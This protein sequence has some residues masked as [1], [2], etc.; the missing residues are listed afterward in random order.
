MIFV[1]TVEPLEETCLI[2][3]SGELDRSTADRL[4]SALDAARA[5]GV[6]ALLDL[7]AVSFIDTAGLRV[8]LRSAR[9][10][11]AHDQTWFIVGASSAVWR[12]V[13]LSGTRSQLPLVAPPSSIRIAPLQTAPQRLA[14]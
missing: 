10:F 6:T 5:D 1:V 8:L 9:A 11:D 12:L 14:G 3:A 2:R 13:E 7:S 4:S